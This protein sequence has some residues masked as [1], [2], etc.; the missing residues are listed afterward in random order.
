MML[1]ELGGSGGMLDSVTAWIGSTRVATYI[2]ENSFAF[3]WLESLHVMA[4]G[5][6]LGV[7]SIVD[8]RLM[9]L[10][11]TGYR[12]SRLLRA[13]LPLTW[14]AFAVA[15]VTG[16]LMFTSQPALYLKT[17]AFQIK[18]ALLVIAG[19]NMAIFHLWTHR[20]MAEWDEHGPVPLA[21]RLAGLVS[22][23]LWIGVVFAGRFVGFTLDAFGAM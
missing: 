12:T 10:A 23:C 21:A 4:I 6:V 5:L 15:F 3:P 9:G 17:F 20:R 7:I 11:G 19:L 14:G 8:L 1:I 18:L 16:A 13:L 2:Q 22:L